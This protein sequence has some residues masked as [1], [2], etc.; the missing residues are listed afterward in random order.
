M[1]Q[2]MCFLTESFRSC[3]LLHYILNRI[4][5]EFTECLMILCAAWSMVLF[6]RMLWGCTID[7]YLE[8]PNQ[9]THLRTMHIS[10]PVLADYCITYWVVLL[11]NSQNV[12]WFF[13][14]HGPWSC[15]NACC[16][17]VQLN[18]ID[19]YIELPNPSTPLCTMHIRALP[20]AAA[21]VTKTNY[22]DGGP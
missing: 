20:G 14:L 4:A 11:L 22:R 17:D 6:K 16:G 21:K 5:L 15:L 8:L 18:T 13:V 3:R 1:K 19:K 12:S 2:L 10:S 7:K 9:S